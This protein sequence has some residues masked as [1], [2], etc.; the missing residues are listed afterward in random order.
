ME[1]LISTASHLDAKNL[2]NFHLVSRQC[3]RAGLS[4]IPQNGL[5]VLNTAGSL[6]ELKHLLESPSIA[7]NTKDIMIIQG[8]WP[9]CSRQ[10][11]ETHPL[12]CHGNDRSRAPLKPKSADEAFA[13]YSDFVE[14]QVARRY[15]DNVNDLF[16][17]L[18]SL[19]NLHAVTV[20]N[21]QI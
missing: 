7:N 20:T 19:P 10:E 6:R 2:S 5:S 12:L 3:A 14:E 11:W 4:L 13:A 18:R 9:V 21:V 17:I 8:T 15:H 16:K 1:V